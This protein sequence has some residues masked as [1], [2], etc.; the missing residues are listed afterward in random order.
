MRGLVYVGEGKA[1]LSD[2]LELRRP[3][4][5]DVV[6]RIVAAGLCHTDLSVLDGTIP[7]PAPAA[8]GHEGAGIVEEVGDAV[9]LVRP[10][11]HVVVS[12]IA[13]CGLCRACN[14]GHPTRCR[15]SI[16]NRSEPFTFRG[17]PCSNFAATSSLAE[18]TVIKEIQA[19]PIPRDVP[20]ES[21]CLIAC[22][23]LTGAGSVWNA[24]RVPRGDTAVVFGL[25]GVGLSAIQALRIAG[26]SRIVAVDMIA[27]KGP[28]A[29]QLGA[30]DFLDASSV[31]DLGLALREL[32]PFSDTV[33]TGPFGAGGVDWA[34]ECTGHPAVLRTAI[35]IL[36][37]GGT[38][39]AVGV[40]GP[41]TEVGAPV[42]HMVHL[43]R[44]LMG[45][46]YGECAPRRDIPMI[47]DYY[48]RG[49][50][51]L[52]EMVTKRYPITDWQQALDDLHHGR[53][54]RGVLVM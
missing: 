46:R 36:E 53:L 11:D 35:D 1:E 31:S 18:R 4:P 51:H 13:N 29:L 47:I 9:T 17:A 44:T 27:A 40:P 25:G 3:G 32:F 52:D 48:R 20:L 7:W 30:T 12:T 49:L 10:G 14:T 33:V 21:A 22:G 6:V 2:D 19:V 39:V 41:G 5:R 38:A 28:L 15:E 24:A 50:F 43:D 54:A 45:V 16:G 34:F 8:M 23:V 42:N 37:W 26:A